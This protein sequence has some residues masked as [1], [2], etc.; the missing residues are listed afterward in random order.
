MLDGAIQVNQR[1]IKACKIMEAETGNYFISRQVYETEM[2]NSTNSWQ[3]HQHKIKIASDALKE[4]EDELKQ[5]TSKGYRS[6]RCD[7]YLQL[8]EEYAKAIGK[9]GLLTGIG[10]ESKYLM[11]VHDQN[12]RMTGGKEAVKILAEAVA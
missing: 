7:E 10:M 9:A 6:R 3:A 5:A 11:G 2:N 8:V 12:E 4:K 1:H